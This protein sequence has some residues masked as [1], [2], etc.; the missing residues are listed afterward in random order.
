MKGGEGGDTVQG[1]RVQVFWKQKVSHCNLARLS[2]ESAA[3]AVSTAEG[4][5][6]EIMPPLCH[7]QPQ[8]AFTQ[9]A[10]LLAVLL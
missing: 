5:H 2:T 4:T 7:I 10:H 3:A 9:V 6:A 1:E 8:T